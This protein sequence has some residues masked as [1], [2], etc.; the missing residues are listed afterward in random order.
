M[1][2]FAI[3]HILR[4]NMMNSLESVENHFIEKN[5]LTLQN[6]SQVLS[7][8]VS[9]VQ[10]LISPM[11]TIRSYDKNGRYF[12]LEKLAR[13]NSMGIWEYNNIHF[14]RFGTLKNTLLSVINNSIQGM[15]ASQ[16]K[17]VMGMETRNFLFQYKDVSGIKRE[18]VGSHYVYFSSGPGRFSRQ[19]SN[20]K[21]GLA[22]MAPLEGTAAI[23]VLVETIK[24]PDFTFEQLS[25]HLGKQGIKIKP[26][27]IEDFLLFY[28]I[29]KKHKIS[30]KLRY[31]MGYEF[32]DNTQNIHV[33]E[34]NQIVRD[35]EPINTHDNAAIK[36]LCHVL[37]LWALDGKKH[38]DGMGFPFDRPH[39]EFYRRLHLLWEQ[40]NNL[41]GKGIENKSLFKCV[42]RIIGDLSPLVNDKQCMSAFK[43]LTKK[44]TA[45]DNLRQALSIAQPN[46][47]KALNDTGEDIAMNTIENRVN[48]FNDNLVITKGYHKSTAYQKIV[49]QINKYREKLFCDPVKIS[50]PEGDSFIHP[51]RTNN[52]LEQFFRGMRRSY[53]RAT[54][55]NSI[56]KKLKSIIADTPL[57]K[58][59]DNPEYMDAILDG[60]ESLEDTFAEIIQLKVMRKMQDAKKDKTKIPRNV[61]LLIRQKETMQK[62]LHLI[63][64]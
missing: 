16:I 54:G 47:T 55:N 34:I 60:K 4:Q 33:G 11:D 46:T 14:S 1:F 49:G 22:S 36:K 31:R 6:L 56:C 45:F 2:V 63:A 29:E 19:L 58:N 3:K 52:I 8:S 9:K 5:V 24:Y 23:S 25:K 7:V 37:L 59:L 35:L 53:R 61:L 21:Q 41:Q 27:I 10:R 57:V 12:S 15:N 40:L 43:G 20:R 48:Q 28:G 32:G 30:V 51:Q 13:F 26:A 18:K 62:L 17:D 38:G 39:V 64:N 50:T 42:T 44:Q